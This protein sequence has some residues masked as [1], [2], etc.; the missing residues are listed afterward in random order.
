MPSSLDRC[1]EKLTSTPIERLLPTC[2]GN[3]SASP[4]LLAVFGLVLNGAT[5]V[6]PVRASGRDAIHT[7]APIGDA[8][9]KREDVRTHKLNVASDT[10]RAR[11]SLT[12]NAQ[13]SEGTCAARGGYPLGRWG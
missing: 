2:R 13:A 10:T 3:R 11:A 7:A 9:L 5:A 4:A 8:A 6:T 12:P 1:V